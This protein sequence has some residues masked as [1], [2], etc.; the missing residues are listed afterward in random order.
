MKLQ[1]KEDVKELDDFVVV[2]VDFVEQW[3][4]EFE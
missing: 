4:L 3:W 1:M 2:E